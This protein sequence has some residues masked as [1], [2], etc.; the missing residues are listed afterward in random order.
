M[1]NPANEGGQSARSAPTV[2]IGALKLTGAGALAAA[3]VIVGGVVGLVIWARPSVGML[4]SG[5]I[6]LGFTVFWS[7]TAQRGAQTKSEETPSSRAVHQRLMNAAL[8]LLFVPVPGLMWRW[9]PA[10]P[11]VVTAGLGVQ[12]AFALLHVWARLHLGRNW[13]S[14]VQIMTDHE[15]VTTG[16]YRLVRHPIYTAILGMAAGTAI[17]SGQLHGLIGVATMA[18]AYRR[19][20]RLEEERLADT[21]GAA[22]EDYRKRS[23]ALIPGLL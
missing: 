5:L 9:L 11:R 3:I 6:W 21:F 20:I 23:W 1:T 10:G 2:Q 13:S 18:Y 17:V 14:A 15:L 22:W 4:L 12:I 7:I 19:K 8:L 16:P